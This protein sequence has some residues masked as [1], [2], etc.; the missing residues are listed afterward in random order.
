MHPV[1]DVFILIPTTFLFLPQFNRHRLPDST[2]RVDRFP[3]L[4]WPIPLQFRFH[5]LSER[6]NVR[7]IKNSK[8]RIH[9]SCY[10]NF[11]SVLSIVH[12]AV[13]LESN[14][15]NVLDSIL[16]LWRSTH[17]TIDRQAY[18]YLEAPRVQS[19]RLISPM[20]ST[21]PTVNRFLHAQGPSKSSFSG[22]VRPWFLIANR[23]GV[24]LRLFQRPVVQL[25][26]CYVQN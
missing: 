6:W 4:C 17:E 10:H 9:S 2:D 21:Q 13:L 26:N 22:G 24:L 18:S 16:L 15:T 3:S 19:S 14:P 23:H 7:Y 1:V 25:S 8:D 5:F 12:F 11:V 20:N